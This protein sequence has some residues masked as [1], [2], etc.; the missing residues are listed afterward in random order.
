MKRESA[1]SKTI[2]YKT[3]H[4][5]VCETEVAVDQSAPDDVIEPKAYAAILGEGK[6]NK[7]V[8]HEGN[9]DLELAFQLNETDQRHPNVGGFIICEQ[10]AKKIHGHPD[11]AEHYYGKIPTEIADWSLSNETAVEKRQVAAVLAVILLAVMM[12]LVFLL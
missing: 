3:T 5:S 4:C 7:N 2:S 6:L 12:I 9:W 10:C 8:E 11:D 1:V